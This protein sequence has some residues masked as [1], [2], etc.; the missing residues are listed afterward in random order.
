MDNIDASKLYNSFR[1]LIVGDIISFQNGVLKNNLNY[2][3]ILSKKNYPYD[4]LEIS[5]EVTND[6]IFEFIRLNLLD[7][8]IN[9]IKE[10]KLTYSLNTIFFMATFYSIIIN[11]DN[12]DKLVKIIEKN[13]TNFYFKYKNEFINDNKY[14]SLFKYLNINK[15]LNNNYKKNDNSSDPLVRSL[16]FGFYDKI[17]NNYEVIDIIIKTTLITHNN[18]ISIIGSVCSALFV[19]YAINK[20]DIKLWL[21]KIINLISSNS[22][23]ELYLNNCKVD[24]NKYNMDLKLYIFKLNNYIDINKKLKIDNIKQLNNI[25][26]RY[27]NYYLTYTEN[28]NNYY[29]GNYGDDC[30][31]I[32]YDTLIKQLNLNYSYNKLFIDCG[33]NSGNNNNL[34]C[35]ASF[36]FGLMFKYNDISKLNTNE[37]MNN[38]FKNILKKKL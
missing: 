26:L 2:K 5:H 13:L 14:E 28:K 16:L 25:G 23:K 33:L 32:V 3:G 12:N 36:I 11:K 30:I 4:I 19:Y 18:G 34:F 15:K 9:I 17:D 6:M 21:N 8:M 22:F 29:P 20:I 37:E 35:I 10:D 1:F 31:L 24:E 7:G 27:N 38:L